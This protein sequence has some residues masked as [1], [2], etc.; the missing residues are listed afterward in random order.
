MVVKQFG[1]FR[2]KCACY[3]INGISVN[4]LNNDFRVHLH[5]DMSMEFFLA[6]LNI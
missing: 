6:L 4:C 5:K 1:K 2:K 3:L